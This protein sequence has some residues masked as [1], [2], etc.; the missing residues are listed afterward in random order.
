MPAWNSTR[1]IRFSRREREREG[2]WFEE[3]SGNSVH[4]DS[5][6]RRTR[7]RILERIILRI[8][9]RIWICHLTNAFSTRFQL[10][11]CK[12]FKHD[13]TRPIN[14]D[15]EYAKSVSTY[16]QRLRSS[17][18]FP[19]CLRQR[20]R[21]PSRNIWHAYLPLET[22]LRY[23][24]LIKYHSSATRS[25]SHP[26]EREIRLLSR[27]DGPL[28]ALFHAGDAENIFTMVRGGGQMP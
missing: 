1:V 20:Q 21:S 13:S 26:H 14:S 11:V 12:N 15:T 8:I 28:H 25:I 22:P 16:S 17:S 3:M 4:V 27:A 5:I 24:A 23:E 19:A 2:F 18:S 6:F 7:I 10:S 9:R